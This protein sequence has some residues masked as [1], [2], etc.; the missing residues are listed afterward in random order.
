[1]KK[2]MILL[3]LFISFSGTALFSQ[4]E[5]LKNYEGEI[6]ELE[7]R[8]R[9]ITESLDYLKKKNVDSNDIITMY[10]ETESLF[11]ELKLVSE[12]KDYDIIN[13]FLQHRLTALEE[14]TLERVSLAKRMDFIYI[15]MVTMGSVAIIVMSVYSVYM[16]SR[17]K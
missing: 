11:R 8:F 2:F 14:K 15:I 13:R 5:F 16:Y 17:R 6:S 4:N 1:M 7:S 3:I 10:T 9:N 12:L